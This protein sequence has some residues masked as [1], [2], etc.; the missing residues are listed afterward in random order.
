MPPEL[1]VA[2]SGVFVTVALA[3]ASAASWWL[4]RSAPEQ[5]LRSLVRLPPTSVMREQRA[6]AEEPDPT[7]AR[8]SRLIPKSAKDMSRLQRRLAQAGYP[9]FKSAVYYAL[10]ELLLPL[11][12]GS[13][14]LF[15]FGLFVDQFVLVG[16]MRLLGKVIQDGLEALAQQ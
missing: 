4:A 7:L 3:A 6:L 10:A 8:L 2:I 15:G 1:L 14:V 5:R 13:G 9:H 16:H 12:F 11:V